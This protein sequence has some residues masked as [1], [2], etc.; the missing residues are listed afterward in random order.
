[1]DAAAFSTA[2][3]THLCND[4][5]FDIDPKYRFDPSSQLDPFDGELSASARRSLLCSVFK[6]SEV[7]SDLDA[8]NRT[9]LSFLEANHACK[10]WKLDDDMPLAVGY[11]IAYA[12]ETLH[13]W[14]EPQSGT[15]LEMT[16]S[17]IEVVARFGPGRS[18][19]LGDKPS[20]YYFKVGDAHLSCT[21]PF[22][23]SWYDQSVQFNPLCEAAEMARKARHGPAIVVDHGTLSFVP[24]SYLTRRAILTEPSLNTYFQLGA[25]SVI[26]NVLRKHTGIDLSTQNQK[27]QELAKEGS[28]SG[29]YA[30]IDLKQCSDY[31]AMSMVNYM[32]PRSV[33][34]WIRILR[35]PNVVVPGLGNFT[36][37]M[38]STMGNGFTFPLQTAL[39]TAVVLGV[40][41]TLDI[42]LPNKGQ[43][44]NF[45]VFGDDIVCH[46]TAYNLICKTVKV[47]GLVVNENKSYSVG[48]F[49]ESCGKDYLS[50]HDIR[51]VYIK[52]YTTIQDYISAF[53]R[54]AVWSAKHSTPLPCAL[55]FLRSCIGEENFFLVPPDEPVTAGVWSPYP[56]FGQQA[57]GLWEYQAFYPI[58]AA[59]KIEPQLETELV[60]PSRVAKKWVSA[61]LQYS[62]GTI[63]E[64]AALKALLYGAIRRGKVTLRLESQVAFRKIRRVTP[65]WGYSVGLT[66]ELSDLARDRWNRLVIS[67]EIEK[68]IP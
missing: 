12:R 67:Q 54:L 3:W 51:G 25:G 62:D 48:P 14:F 8:E 43:P 56:P 13:R 49:R 4:L 52:R 41:K 6:K 10:E 17:S 40:Y 22:I 57:S 44:N 15:E 37:W 53:N 58:P 23:R 47:L 7:E 5:G 27:N 16:Q 20:Q 31:I 9:L 21:L 33:T 28:I 38:A 39:L 18:A 68:M 36:L 61:L 42:E 50:G 60:K 19:K 65:R 32:F 24:K 26:E 64:P 35:T 66:S 34:D 1:M 59:L 11:A 55:Q 2:L 30:T 63:N 29:E 46:S 45:G